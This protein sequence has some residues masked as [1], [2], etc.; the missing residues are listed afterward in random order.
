MDLLYQEISFKTKTIFISILMKQDTD[1]NA[2]M[3]SFCKKK[4]KEEK[5]KN[6]KPL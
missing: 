5:K 4:K 3:L 1:F 2:M 6:K